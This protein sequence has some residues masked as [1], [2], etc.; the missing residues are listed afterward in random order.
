MTVEECAGH[1]VEEGILVL[2]QC[3]S[4]AA[5]QVRISVSDQYL[6]TPE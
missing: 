1:V 2:N 6:V 3:V 5:A 4:S